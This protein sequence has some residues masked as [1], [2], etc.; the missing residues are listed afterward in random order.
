MGAVGAAVHSL[1]VGRM[2]TDQD[3]LFTASLEDLGG[4]KARALRGDV[5]QLGAAADR[6]CSHECVAHEEVPE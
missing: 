2:V 3:S 5:W 4:V 6:S 1:R